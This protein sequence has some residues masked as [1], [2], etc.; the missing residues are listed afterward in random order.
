MKQTRFMYIHNLW[1]IEE[2]VDNN[3]QDN[4]TIKKKI[5]YEQS[6]QDKY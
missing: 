1:K 2:R 4:I 6:W 5:R 3:K